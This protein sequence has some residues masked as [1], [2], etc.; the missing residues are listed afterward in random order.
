M[1]MLI[2]PIASLGSWKELQWRAPRTAPYKSSRY[3]GTRG[4]SAPPRK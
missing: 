1:F 3:S 4:G 2:A